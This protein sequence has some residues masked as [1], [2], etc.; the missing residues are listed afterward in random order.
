M[1][2]KDFTIALSKIK[3]IPL[4]AETSQFKMAPPYREALLQQQKD[5]MKHARQRCSNGVVLSRFR[6]TN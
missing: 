2:F 5:K 1:N 3:N 6:V 4:P